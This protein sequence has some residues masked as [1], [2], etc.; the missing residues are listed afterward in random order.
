MRRDIPFL[1]PALFVVSAIAIAYQIALMRILS[2][3]QW[4]HFA[5]MIISIAMLG[6]GAGGTLMT[7]LKPRLRGIEA[8]TFY[9]VLCAFTL[10]LPACYALSQSIPF[11]TFHLVSQ[12]D[13][14]GWLLLLYT[15]LAIPF[16]LA[17][18]C[19]ALALF[20]LP[21]RVGRVYFVDLLG[22]GVGA[23]LV[24]AMLF[25][26]PPEQVPYVLTLPLY[27][28]ALLVG[29]RQPRRFR[30]PLILLAAGTLMIGLGPGLTPVRVSEYKVIRYTKQFP[31]A[32]MLAQRQSPLSQL[33]VIDSAMI[34]ETPGQ[35]GNYPFGTYGPLPR[36]IGL[37][38][39]G[40]SVSVAHAFTGDWERFAFLDY[41][42]PALAYHV[43]DTPRVLV[44]GAGGGTDVWMGLYHG[45]E[46]VT[47]V[48]V[49]PSV[50]PIMRDLLHEFSGGLYDRPDVET[51]LAEGRGFLRARGGSY[52]VIQIAL[53]DAFNAAA[54]GV[55]ALSESYLYTREAVELY[56]QHL[57]ESGVLAVTRWLKTPPRDAIKVFATL[58]EALERQGVA[59]P[60]NHLA[61][62]RSWNAATVLMSRAPWTE[63]QIKAIREFAHTRG[64]DLDWLPGLE[65]HE[66]NQFTIMDEPVY[67][68]AAL[69]LLSDER[70]TFYRSYLFNVRPATDDRPHFFQFF[71]WSTLR[72]L[73]REMGVEWVPF[74]EW[75][76]IALL[77]TLIQ[78]A[79]A[80]ILLVG[81]PAWVLRRQ[82]LPRGSRRSVGAYFTI[83]GLAFMFLEIAF[84]QKFMLFLTYP[85]Y[86]VAVVLAG[87]LV[88]S[89]WGSWFADR[90]SLPPRTLLRRAIGGLVVLTLLYTWWL[91][92][93]FDIGAAW[94]DAARVGV[95]FAFIAPLAFCMGMPLPLGLQWISHRREALV[96][97]AWAINGVSSV[98]GASLAT[99]AAIHFGFRWLV[100][101][102]A[103]IYLL[104]IPA[105]TYLQKRVQDAA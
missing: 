4:H 12:R 90:T 48:E 94:S 99:F 40:G 50:F 34:R 103:I 57:S 16:L 10:S 91:P 22:S 19:T 58:V 89:G 77:A 100:W 23:A 8:D 25:G 64:F 1:L 6:F 78:A 75:G 36:Q 83:L 66:V 105:F 56:Y 81:I 43:V 65:P 86:A 87:F 14:L 3:A 13:Q 76:Y 104:A 102:A 21:Q 31:D 68:Q 84:I 92:I 61:F 53:L 15:V 20:I 47:A 39:D 95:A 52:D 9:W 32:E 85:V 17:S 49:D 93:V 88:C 101:G 7:L 5:Y 67:Y 70:E 51:V 41:V 63:P 60:G 74:V 18:I 28:I 54:A 30:V 79:I 11:E 71:K 37:F 73:I 24:V 55:Y 96:P 59:E 62:I 27:A 69:A 45:A 35:L 72:A 26:F 42:T 97:W 33:T 80:G 29:R 46:Q 98:M 2:I 44:I 82:A 38:F